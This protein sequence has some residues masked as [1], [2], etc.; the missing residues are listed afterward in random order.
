MPIL[1]DPGHNA[2]VS[3]MQQR[4][5]EWL[6]RPQAIVLVTAHWETD[7]PTVSAA[8]KHPLLYDYYGFPPE[9]YSLEYNPPGSP[10]VA[11]RVAELLGQAGIPA[12]LDIKRGWDHGVFV[13]LLLLRP[14]ADIPV[15]QVS[16]VE[17][18]DPEALFALGQAL[19]P[20]RRE[21]V[22]IVGSGMSYHNLRSIFGNT[23]TGNIDFETALRG[24]MELPPG[25]ERDQKV[26][27]WA[28]LPYA[29]ECH[30]RGQAEHL[31]PLIVCCGS[32]SQDQLKDSALLD[33]LN[34]KVSAFLW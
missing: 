31:S 10:A 23:V 13:P 24:L 29:R 7:I 25:A 22:A 6:G 28:T 15:V 26:R 12:A 16:V 3:F 20:L 2:M 32:A 33:L 27:Q 34:V 30:P 11:A 4:G 17:S 19:A 18:Q 1:G 9:S 21:G 8:S 14:E 5:R